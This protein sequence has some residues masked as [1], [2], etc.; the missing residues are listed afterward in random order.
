MTP[1]LVYTHIDEFAPIVPRL[2]ETTPVS[3]TVCELPSAAGAIE[4][5]E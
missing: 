3:R 5:V 4:G 1:Q 2:T